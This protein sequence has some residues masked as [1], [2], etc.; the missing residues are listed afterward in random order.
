MLLL[1]CPYISNRTLNPHPMKKILLTTFTAGLL[2]LALV[3]SASAAKGAKGDKAGKKAAHALSKTVLTTYDK[4]ANGEI[5]GD[6]KDALRKAFETDASLK[7]LDKN[8]DGKLDDEEIAAVK[9]HKKG[10][11][12]KK[13]A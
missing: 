6:E 10:G 3:T 1:V 7:A 11:K 8:S 2:S 9:G 12:K 5:D 13:T 4:N